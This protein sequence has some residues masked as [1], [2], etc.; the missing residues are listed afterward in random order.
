MYSGIYEIWFV[1]KLNFS[2]RIKY[3]IKTEGK[4]SNLHN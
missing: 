1:W 2:L 3:Y 4:M